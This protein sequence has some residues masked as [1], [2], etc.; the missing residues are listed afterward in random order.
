MRFTIVRSA[1]VL[2]VVACLS[3]CGGSGH[4][5]ISASVAGG[6]RFQPASKTF[7]ITTP[8]GWKGLNSNTLS[9]AANDAARRNPE[10][11]S[12]K[13]GIVAVGKNPN[14][15]FVVDATKEGRTVELESGFGVNGIARSSPLDVNLSNAAAEQAVAR[16]YDSQAAQLHFH[17]TRV[18]TTLA[19]HPALRL[20]YVMP[21]HTDA[22]T[23]RAREAD[24]VLVWGKHVY[25]VSLTAPVTSSA[26][27]AS[28][29]S[30]ILNSFTIS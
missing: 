7:T 5:P 8:A 4:T 21:V 19:G 3:G 13:A 2:A 20:T 28:T 25:I 6:T 27:Y 17:I 9:E 24:T 18:Q 14:L 26:D 1:A 11:A 23:V 12:L 16:Q 22:G 15:V 30:R 29:F 10:F